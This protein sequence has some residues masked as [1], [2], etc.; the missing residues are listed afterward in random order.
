MKHEAVDNGAWGGQIAISMDEIESHCEADMCTKRS[1]QILK[2][3]NLDNESHLNR[4]EK[5]KP[6]ASPGLK[7]RLFWFDL[8]RGGLQALAAGRPTPQT[9][10]HRV[11][12]LA[13]TDSI[14]PTINYQLPTTTSSG[15]GCSV[16]KK[17]ETAPRAYEL[18]AGAGWCGC[19]NWE[20]SP[21]GYT[22]WP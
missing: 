15:V 1:R 12:R 6:T 13:Q 3:L 16:F 2:R 18:R 7:T 17:M 10:H 21:T 14:K 22:P 20:P 19:G 5:A 9:H 4:S 11:A 8:I